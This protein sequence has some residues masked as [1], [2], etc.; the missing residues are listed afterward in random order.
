MGVL[1]G[2]VCSISKLPAS[3]APLAGDG[4][5]RARWSSLTA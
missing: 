2:S 1:A 3:Q 4:R 5:G